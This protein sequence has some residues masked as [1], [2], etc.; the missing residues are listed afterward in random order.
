VGSRFSTARVWARR[1]IGI[2]A[3]YA[4]AM[5]MVLA[6]VIVSQSIAAPASEDP[7]VICFGG[8]DGGHSQG[9]TQKPLDHATCAVVCTL[10][11]SGT[12]V[13]P[14][15]VTIVDR[16]AGASTPGVAALAAC[17]APS[18]PTPRL[19]QGPPRHA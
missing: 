7:F 17:D 15:T 4:V 19:S 12:A 6:S 11:M 18:H 16:C 2:A 9:P 10:A 5:Q 8:G 14:T 13:L 1:V 3:A